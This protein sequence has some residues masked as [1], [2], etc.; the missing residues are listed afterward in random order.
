MTDQNHHSRAGK[1]TTCNQPAPC[2]DAAE[3]AA[4]EWRD[5]ANVWDSLH[6]YL[7]PIRKGDGGG[8]RPA[9]ASRPPISIIAS[10]LIAEIEDWAWFYASALMDET[11]DYS[12]PASTVQRLRDIAERYGHFTADTDERWVGDPRAKDDMPPGH[13]QRVGLDYCDMAH[14]LRRKVVGLITQPP[15]PRFMG[16]CMRGDGCLG[17]VYLKPN[18]SLARCTT[19]DQGHD[20][21]ELRDRLWRAFE[22]RLMR[23]DELRVAVNSL[24][25]PGTKKVPGTTVRT[26][27]HRGRLVPV[28]REPEMFR[29]SDALDLAGISIEEPARVA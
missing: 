23:R 9:P 26:W 21:A 18:E 14:E 28:I 13:W 3:R 1:C 5:L 12:A 22:S 25:T 11:R 15:P 29:L 6:E 7:V 20:M 27:I 8:S 2:Q 16:P 10:D 19:C 4:E 24:R 17:D